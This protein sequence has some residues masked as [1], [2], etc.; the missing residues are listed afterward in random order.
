M[1]PTI[2]SGPVDPWHW[3]CAEAV[4]ARI[5]RIPKAVI[6]KCFIVV[7]SSWG[8]SRDSLRLE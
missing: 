6:P 1:A 8:T 2:T 7:P 4:E 3:V 5:A